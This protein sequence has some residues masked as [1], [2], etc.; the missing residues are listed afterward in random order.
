MSTSE[1]PKHLQKTKPKQPVPHQESAIP[2]EIKTIAQTEN[3]EISSDM[4]AMVQ[5][6]IRDQLDRERAILREAGS[7]ALKIVGGAFALLLAIFTVFGLTTWKDVAKQTTDYMKQRVDAL[8]QNSDSETGVRQTLNDLVNR[9]IVAAE[10]TSLSHQAGKTLDLPKFEWDRLRAWL[11][12]E[13]LET[14]QFQDALAILNAQSAGRKKADANGFLSE[15]LNPPDSSP[16]RWIVRQPEKRLAIMD[17]FSDTD[18]GASAVAIATSSASEDLRIAAIR[19]VRNVNYSDGFDKLVAIASTGDDGPLKTQALL[20][21]AKLRPTNRLFLA[22]LRKLMSESNS[23][24]M[25]NAVEIVLQW[26]KDRGSGSYIADNETSMQVLASSKELLAFAFHGGVN[27]EVARPRATFPT[28]VTVWIPTSKSTATGLSLTPQEF[29][30]LKPYWELLA[31]A[32]N[33]A[34]NKKVSEYMFRMFG[35]EG[36]F[37]AAISMGKK[38]FLGIKSETGND[39][40]LKASDAA[41]MFLLPKRGSGDLLVRWTKDHQTLNNGTISGF[42]GQDFGFSLH[43]PPVPAAH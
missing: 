34:D 22:E 37:S 2:P 19:Y 4:K 35:G 36:D 23:S 27:I 30:E 3:G 26:W 6:E 14:Q 29:G 11:K 15:M 24:S 28:N 25:S 10:L 16:Y 12:I 38:S 43:T 1:P 40:T 21:S 9:A 18:L 42:S 41:E 32:A 5:A 33:E 17:N 20:T 8:I 7:L 31:D 13:S 39:I